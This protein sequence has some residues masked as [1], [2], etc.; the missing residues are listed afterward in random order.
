[1]KISLLNIK[2]RRKE[3]INKDFMGG[4]GWAF[5]IGNSLPARLIE[6]VKKT[7]EHLPIMSYGYLASIFKNNGHEVE[8]VENRIPEAD[9]V[10]FQ[11][12][13]VDYRE[14][15]DWLKKIKQKNRGIIGVYGP[16]PSAR[17]DIFS[18]FADFIIAGEPE[19]VAM[20][21]SNKWMPSGIV[22]SRAFEN[23]D[24]LPFPNWDIFPVKTYSYFPALKEKPFLP[25]LSSRGCAFKCNYCPYRVL[26]KWRARKADKVLEE[27]EQLVKH[28]N[29]RGLLFRDPLFGLKKDLA[30]DIG[31]GLIERK[32]NI[33]WACETRLDLL[34]EPMLELL[35]K[36]GLRVI[37][38]GIESGNNEILM[39]ASKKPVEAAH[40]ERIIKFCDDLGIRVT[41][42][43]ILG[44]PDD[45]DES[46]RRT[47][48]YAKKLNT[49]VAQFFIFTPFPGTEFFE[50]IR[51]EIIETD[52][53][54][55]DSYTPVFRH[56]NLAP[57]ALL[58]WKEKAFKEYYYRPAWFSRLIRRSIRDIFE[59]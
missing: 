18:G 32:Y 45:T 12:T 1:M 2:S 50:Q 55:F 36:A 38:V 48:N 7:G 26:Y 13:M 8:F 11:P 43:Y 49:H 10:I 16:F 57:E 42:F 46:I 21:I 37:N 4:Y 31:N 40:Q 35:Y 5:H 24:E 41:A 34:D 27:I 17:P 56:K 58:Y 28:H 14:E 39:K 33:R 44:L 54:R 52:W 9:L 51:D 23:L 29:T 15:I 20:K 30:I 19:E 25:I 47:I 53:E 3:C 6:F 59:I 22:T